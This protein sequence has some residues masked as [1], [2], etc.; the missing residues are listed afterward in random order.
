[1]KIKN[2][3]FIKKFKIKMKNKILKIYHLI[4]KNNK[5]EFKKMTKIKIL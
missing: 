4:R 3:K 5:I 2:H 1:M